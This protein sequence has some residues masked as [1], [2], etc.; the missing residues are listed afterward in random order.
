MG[1]DTHHFHLPV[2][3]DLQR[4]AAERDRVCHT[5]VAHQIAIGQKDGFFS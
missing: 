1:G 4:E 5:F 3:C 2:P